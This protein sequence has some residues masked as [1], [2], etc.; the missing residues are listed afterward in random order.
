MSQPTNTSENTYSKINRRDFFTFLTA[1]GIIPAVL[2][3]EEIP[4]QEQET[5]EITEEVLQYAEKIFGIPFT[6]DDRELMLR[7]V[8]SNRE[9]YEKI[10]QVTIDNAVSPAITFSALLPGMQVKKEKNVFKPSKTNPNI[11]SMSETDIA[12]LSVTHL[13]QLIKSRQISSLDLTKL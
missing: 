13:S 6:D 12:F 7:S 2:S 9:K 1:M 3:G 11:K 8:V 10:R 5:S 4:V